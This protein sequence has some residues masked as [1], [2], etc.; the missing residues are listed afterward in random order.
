VKDPQFLLALAAF[1]GLAVLAWATLD[2]EF[3]WLT[4]LVLAVFVTKT[5]LVVLKRKLD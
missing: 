5:V 2:G 3:L 4:W 1:A